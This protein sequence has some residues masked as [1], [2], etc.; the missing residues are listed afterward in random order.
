MKARHIIIT[1]M[2]TPV[3]SRY[4]IS[5]DVVHRVLDGE[6]IV[7]NLESGT[8]FGLNA[9]GTRVWRLIE[10]GASRAAIIEQIS[11]EFG[12]PIDDVRSDVD[13]LLTALQSKGLVTAAPAA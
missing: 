2:N 13:E 7:L 6:T 4:A 3:D 5:Q 1:I 12:H 9:T 10:E 11:R 8:Y